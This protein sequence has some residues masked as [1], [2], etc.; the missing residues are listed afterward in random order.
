M[1]TLAAQGDTQGAAAAAHRLFSA[2]AQAGQT[3]PAVRLLLLLGRMHLE[4]SAP[5]LALPYLLSCRAHCKQLHLDVMG[6]EVAVMLVRGATRACTPAVH[7]GPSCSVRSPGA[8]PAACCALP[9]LARLEITI[10]HVATPR[11]KQACWNGAAFYPVACPRQSMRC[12]SMRVHAALQAKVWHTLG[13]QHAPRAQHEVE[14][15]LPLLL[16]HGSLDARSRA[17]IALAEILLARSRQASEMAAR[18]PR[19]TPA[20]T[21]RRMPCFQARPPLQGLAEVP[22]PSHQAE[23][24]SPYV[25]PQ[26]P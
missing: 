25:A 24:A 8:R 19:C 1:R 5:L 13:E 10:P 7:R 18:S 3:L 6:A 23:C 4:A 26:R 15:V 9:H 14:A 11:H 22:S 17:L 21:C 12:S 2:A 20:Y 16:A